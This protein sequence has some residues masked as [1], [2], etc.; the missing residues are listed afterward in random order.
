MLE[1]IVYFKVREAEV[2]VK[3]QFLGAKIHGEAC[4]L[5]LLGLFKYS[6]RAIFLDTFIEHM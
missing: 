5:F 1:T 6:L 2:L 4:L 3:L